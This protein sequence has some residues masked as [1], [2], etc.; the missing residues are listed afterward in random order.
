MV[1]IENGAWW[2]RSVSLPLSFSGIFNW[3]CSRQE[4]LSVMA[5]RSRSQ[6]WLC[7]SQSF[8]LVLKSFSKLLL[9]Q[10]AD[11]KES[12]GKKITILCGD[13]AFVVFWFFAGEEEEDR[14][15]RIEKFN[16]MCFRGSQAIKLVLRT[17]SRRASYQGK[18]LEKDLW[19]ASH[20]MQMN[21]F[22][23]IWS[24]WQT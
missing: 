19:N 13:S 23:E 22:G 11:L 8:L 14:S 10:N 7:R 1:L 9:R 6:V 24:W 12:H 4:A 5:V 18:N 15:G 20:F 17:A 16:V 21:T 3:L 2:F